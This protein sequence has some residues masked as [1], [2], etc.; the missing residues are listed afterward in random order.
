MILRSA[1]NVNKV[2]LSST[3]VESPVSG[4]FETATSM[5]PCTRSS[6]H[7][8]A[9]EPSCMAARARHSRSL[10]CSLPSAGR[11]GALLGR[12]RMTQKSTRSSGIYKGSDIGLGLSENRAADEVTGWGG[13]LGIGRMK[14]VGRQWDEL[15]SAR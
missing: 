13:I 1:A 9:Q 11:L 4:P 10:A 3:T 8:L 6:Y 5:S 7:L 14:S 2:L 15:I 12:R